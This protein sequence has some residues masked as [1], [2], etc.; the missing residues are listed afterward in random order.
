MFYIAPV[1]PRTSS[2]ILLNAVNTLNVLIFR[3]ASRATS[4]CLVWLITAASSNFL[5]IEAR[6]FNCK[7][8][9]SSQVPWGLDS[10]CD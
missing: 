5:A 4:Q 8:L 3:S 1:N 9:C 2:S 10:L 6:I 7:L